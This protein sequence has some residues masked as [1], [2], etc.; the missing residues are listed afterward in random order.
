MKRQAESDRRAAER[1]A[2]AAKQ[3]RDR[4]L[5]EE[6][7]RTRA[8]LYESEE[9]VMAAI[10]RMRNPKV[11]RLRILYLTAAAAGDLRVDEEIGE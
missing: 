8:L 3:A 2:I 6:R 11:E 10:V 5:R 1:Q 9:K 4:E 7:E